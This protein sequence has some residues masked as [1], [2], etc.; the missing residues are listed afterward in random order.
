MELFRTIVCCALIFIVISDVILAR[1]TNSET[2]EIETLV[3]DIDNRLIRN[4]KHGRRRRKRQILS[5]NM[6][7]MEFCLRFPRRCRQ[8]LA[9]LQRQNNRPQFRV[10]VIEKQCG[11]PPNYY[12]NR[13]KSLRN[14]FWNKFHRTA[15]H[16]SSSFWT[17]KVNFK[18]TNVL[19][20]HGHH[21][22]IYCPF[23]IGM[24]KD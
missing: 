5:R 15:R 20:T 1:P 19:V 18:C 22:S 4:E 10:V 13:Y 12:G 2:K 8:E 11:S 23:V 24:G 9:R 17:Y 6:A 16:D 14:E 3:K 21:A 7:L